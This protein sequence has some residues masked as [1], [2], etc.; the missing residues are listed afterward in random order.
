MV[1]PVYA[2]VTSSVVIVSEEEDAVVLSIRLG[3]EEV[4]DAVTS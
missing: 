1:S 4:K 2:S 3:L